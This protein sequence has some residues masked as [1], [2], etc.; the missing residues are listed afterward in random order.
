MPEIWKNFKSEAMM[1]F[2]RKNSAHYT[3]FEVSSLN[4]EFQVS[5]LGLGIFDQVSFSVSSQNFY[6]VSVSELRVSSTSL[7]KSKAIRR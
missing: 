6:Q 3:N 7:I 5:N 1:T 4:L 2:F